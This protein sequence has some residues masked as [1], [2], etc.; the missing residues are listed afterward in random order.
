MMMPLRHFWNSP[1]LI[2]RVSGA[3]MGTALL[4]L[5]GLLLFWFSQRPAFAVKRVIVDSTGGEFRHITSSQLHAA[6]VETLNG[7]VLSADLQPIQQSLQAIP[8]VRTATVR[9]IWP[10]RLLV[11]IEEQRAVAT[12]TKG[13]LVNAHGEAFAGTS[14]D[15]DEPCVLAA[16][17]G[18]QG[19]EGMVLRRARELQSWVAP[20]GLSLASIRLTDQY[21]WNAVLSSGI[22]LELGRD[23]LAA[24]IEERVQMFVKTQSWLSRRLALEGGASV[25]HADLRYA[26]GYAFRTSTASAVLAQSEQICNLGK[27]SL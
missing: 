7:T 25:V 2:D 3:L 22:T 23:A 26:T 11:R 9:R 12:W 5:L 14:E 17:S 8:W 27:D 1:R 16:L 10:N 4:S 18:P 19:S 13:L 20:L 15:H 24:G 21:A 6:V